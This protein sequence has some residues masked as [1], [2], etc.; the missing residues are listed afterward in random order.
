[1]KILFTI[2]SLAGGGAEKM[3]MQLLT[4]L[5]RRK[6]QVELAVF[7][8]SGRYTSSV[9]GDVVVYDLE[10]K[11]RH[12]MVRATLR[13]AGILRR[14][15]PDLIVSFLPYAS[16]NTIVARQL[17]RT[18]IPIVVCERNALS[19]VLQDDAWGPLKGFLIRRY[20]PLAEAAIAV[21]RG[22][23]DD[24]MHYYPFP[25]RVGVIY[26][27]A[28]VQAIQRQ[29]AEPVEQPWFDDHIPVIISAGR[30]TAQKNFP[31][32]L[33]AFS[34]VRQQMA[35]RLV[36]MGTGAAR[37]QLETLASG[38]GIAS[39]VAF[40][41]YRDNPFAYMSK[42]SLFVLSSSWE[43]FANVIIE[44]M[45]C[46]VPVIATDCPSGPSEIIT[47]G[48]EGILVPVED[49][50]ALTRAMLQVLEDSRLRQRLAD[51][52]RRRAHDFDYRTMVA[53]YEGFFVDMIE[54]RNDV[55]NLP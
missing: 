40:I 30:L 33:R 4:H 25:E 15:C 26:N 38:L 13:L 29:T 17:S 18:H 46:G 5:D 43:G 22:V 20:Y 7:D 2:P 45:A 9:P 27:G 51:S 44:A 32:L 49:V 42:A 41:G 23:R 1:M 48:R 52:G 31:L 47:S 35:V 11:R 16:T 39:D 36:I 14:E 50:D 24:L 6:F 34:R 21:S 55:A 19:K 12:D 3:L 53:A 8:Y 10:K 54:R 37:P 28:D